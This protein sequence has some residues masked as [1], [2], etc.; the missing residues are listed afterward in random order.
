[1]LLLGCILLRSYILS[2]Y[3][4]NGGCILNGG[5]PVIF[6][7]VCNSGA[8]DKLITCLYCINHARIYI[9]WLFHLI[10]CI[11][12][13]IY[14][15]VIWDNLFCNVSRCLNL[16]SISISKSP[17]NRLAASFEYFVMIPQGPPL[18]SKPA[19]VVNLLE[20]HELSRVNFAAQ[21]KI[22]KV[23]LSNNWYLFWCLLITSNTKE[24]R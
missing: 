16:A 5:W 8:L 23:V 1:M 19:N 11:F 22:E 15:L 2:W 13:I 18:S 14:N 4:S 9:V 6:A 3:V 20:S 7:C 24:F 21:K 10:F 12:S 17:S